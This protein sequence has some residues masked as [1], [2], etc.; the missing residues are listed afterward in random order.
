MKRTWPALLFLA[1]LT[2]CVNPR[3]N[4]PPSHAAVEQSYFN[5]TKCGSLSGGVYGR[6]ATQDF[7]SRGAERCVHNWDRVSEQ[8]FKRLAS[9]RFGLR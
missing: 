5:C 4:Q 2:G 1:L 6:G 8:E 9:D 7:R 3:A